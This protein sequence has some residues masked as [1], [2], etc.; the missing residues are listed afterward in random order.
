M[1]QLLSTKLP[2]L[3]SEAILREHVEEV[4]VNLTA[5]PNDTADNV[6]E[7]VRIALEAQKN[8][9]WGK[10]PNGKD[11]L[12]SLNLCTTV[13]TKA[14]KAWFGDWENDPANA[15]KVVDEN[16][17]N[18]LV[19]VKLD[20]GVGSNPKIVVNRISS[21]YGKERIETLLKHPA[22]YV[23]TAKASRWVVDRGL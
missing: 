22:L 4:N 7:R 23:N 5:L 8:G 1:S 12:L 6:F 21:L 18:V 15:S 16:G 13:R 10:A 11:S 20:V 19:A 3:G 2:N 17:A 14:F 9:V